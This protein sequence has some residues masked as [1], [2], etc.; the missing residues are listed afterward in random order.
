MSVYHG[1]P[2]NFKV[3]KPF[4]ASRVHI[5]NGKVILDYEG[6]SLHAT[7][8]KWIALAYTGNKIPYTHNHIE[9]KFIFGV[10]IKEKDYDFNRQIVEI[11][12]K[13]SLEYSL[14]KLYGNG[15]YLYTFNENKFKWVKGLGVNEV[16]SYDE[17]VPQKIEFIK[18]PVKEMKKLGVNF[19]FIN[20]IKKHIE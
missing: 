18:D 17:Q 15:G 13:Q 19:V 5:K 3:A 9:K 4:P 12:G 20:E 10:P 6:I 2:H 14:K 11:H 1:S 16:I 7:P 8:Y